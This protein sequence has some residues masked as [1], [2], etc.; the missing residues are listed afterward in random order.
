MKRKLFRTS[1]EFLFACIVQ[2]LF[3][4]C[5]TFKPYYKGEG[6]RPTDTN[7]SPVLSVFLMSGENDTKGDRSPA[8]N[9]LI[10]Q[11]QNEGDKATLLLLGNNGAKERL[12]DSAYFRK[13]KEAEEILYA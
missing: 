7:R 1:E 12:P 8:L 6:T 11:A 13:R 10:S 4:S 9:L 3:Y 5:A 2:L